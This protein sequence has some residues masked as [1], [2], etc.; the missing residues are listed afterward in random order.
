VPREAAQDQDSGRNVPGEAARDQDSNTSE[1]FFH[2]LDKVLLLKHLRELK[3][4]KTV[5][6]K[7][8]YKSY[9]KWEELN[10][11]QRNKTKSFWVSNLT[12]GVQ[13]DLR[14]LVEADV[15]NETAEEASSVDGNATIALLIILMQHLR[16]KKYFV[17]GKF[18]FRLQNIFF[19]YNFFFPATSPDVREPNST[20]TTD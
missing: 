14:N 11:T 4:E 12:D 2:L 16:R 9:I 13:L 20:G 6:S 15:A 8:F 10:Q 19:S 7:A 5:N 1:A 18:F 17:D 3:A